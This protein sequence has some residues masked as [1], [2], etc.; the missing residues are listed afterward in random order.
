MHYSPINHIFYSDLPRACQ[1]AEILN[2]GLKCPLTE[3]AEWREMNN[4]DLAGMAEG[5]ARERFPGVFADTLQMDEQYPGGESPVQFRNRIE[6]ALEETCRKIILQE[7]S[8]HLLVVTHAGPIRVVCHSI[9]GV[10]W[11][12]KSTDYPVANTGI[13]VAEQKNDIWRLMVKN[14]TQ[15]LQMC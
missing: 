15:H 14:D 6:V 12:N 5:E 7:F 11:T 4:G 8:P 1:T 13:Y 3:A 9:E 2:E 10:V